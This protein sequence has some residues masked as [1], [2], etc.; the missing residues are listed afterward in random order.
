M[1]YEYFYLVS[2]APNE[3]VLMADLNTAG[4]A[5]WR[6]IG[7][8]SRPGLVDRVLMMREV[9]AKVAPAKKATR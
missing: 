5:G 6:A 9:A 7:T 2:P 8:I 3:P 1:T 4:S